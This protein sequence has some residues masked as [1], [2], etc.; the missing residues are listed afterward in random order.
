MS[1][2]GAKDQANNSPIWATLQVQKTANSANRTLL[3][4]NTTSNGFI[5]N[6]TIGLFAIDPAKIKTDGGK[7]AHT[8]WVLRT[9]GT[10]GRAGR[11]MTEV[12]VAGHITTDAGLS[13]YQQSNTGSSSGKMNFSSSI[14]SGLAAVTGI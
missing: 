13:I 1:G 7:I 5:N 9:V 12:L 8:G 4:N 14:N 6:I 11:V 10:G 3:Y 2:S